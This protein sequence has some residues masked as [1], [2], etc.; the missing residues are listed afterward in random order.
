MQSV[1]FDSMGSLGGVIS[2][3]TQCNRGMRF[4]VACLSALLLRGEQ[5][6]SDLTSA[7]V[8]ELKFWERKSE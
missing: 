3:N 4:P 1:D 8:N 6:S 5:V 2:A 7:F